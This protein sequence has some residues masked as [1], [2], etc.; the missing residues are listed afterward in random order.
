MSET[1]RVDSAQK[2]YLPRQVNPWELARQ[3][4]RDLRECLELIEKWLPGHP[5]AVALLSRLQ[6]PTPKDET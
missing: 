1:P 3:L 2:Q 4:E 5:K 6:A